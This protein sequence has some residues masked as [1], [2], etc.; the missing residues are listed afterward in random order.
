MIGKDFIDAIKKDSVKKEIDQYICTQR[1]HPING[2][3]KII[4]VGTNTNTKE[5]TVPPEWLGRVFDSAHQ[6]HKEM[7]QLASR[8]GKPNVT[9]CCIYSNSIK[10]EI[11]WLDNHKIIPGDILFRV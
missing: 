6:L 9:Y 7:D 10:R 8:R 3:I 1:H 11:V 2:K 5:P 4:D